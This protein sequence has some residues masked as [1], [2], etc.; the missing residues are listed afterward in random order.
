MSYFPHS[1]TLAMKTET[2]IR[3]QTS[4]A[5]KKVASSLRAAIESRT[6]LLQAKLP[7]LHAT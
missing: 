4:A 2:G 1:A 7:A 6:V 3:A 5:V